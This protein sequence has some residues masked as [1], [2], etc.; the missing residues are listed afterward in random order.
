MHDVKKIMVLS[1]TTKHCHKAV[2]YGVDLAKCINAELVVVHSIHNPFGLEGWNVPLPSVVN[3]E[4]EYKRMQED[5]K[6]DIDAMIRRESAAGLPIEVI[7]AEGEVVGEVKA[8]VKEK[9][10]DLLIFRGHH[11]SW[12]EHALLGQ[13]NERLLRDL[14]C[15]TMVVKDEPTAVED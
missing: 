14:P 13:T 5:A 12:L 4:A 1:R 3:L 6:K 9:N 15:S 8:L 10:I 11:E 2:H 7:I